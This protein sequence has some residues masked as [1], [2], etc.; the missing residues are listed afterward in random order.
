MTLNVASCV[1]ISSCSGSGAHRFTKGSG[2]RRLAM[3][4]RQGFASREIGFGNQVA[5]SL[6][7]NV[8]PKNGHLD[9]VAECPLCANSGHWRDTER[10]SV[11]AI[12]EVGFTR[13]LKPYFSK[14]DFAVCVRKNEKYCSASG[15]AFALNATG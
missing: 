3:Q 4:L 8:T 13:K 7:I 15:L 2:L 10:P 1:L 5:Q 14:I 12:Q 9:S 11:E 6:G